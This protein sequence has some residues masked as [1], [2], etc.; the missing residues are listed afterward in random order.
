MTTLDFIELFQQQNRSLVEENKSKT[1]I[2]QIPVENQNNLNK[3][4]RESNLTTKISNC[5][6]KIKQKDTYS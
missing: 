5:Y 4:E 1:T 2:I 3:V 6:M